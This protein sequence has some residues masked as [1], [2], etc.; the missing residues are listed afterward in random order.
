VDYEKA[1]SGKVL[2]GANTEFEDLLEE[3]S[4]FINDTGR[5]M[6]MRLNDIS[7]RLISMKPQDAEFVYNTGILVG[8]MDQIAMTLHGFLDSYMKYRIIYVSEASWKKVGDN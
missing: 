6:V 1:D 8:K 5:Q 3:T 4:K 2:L 7:N